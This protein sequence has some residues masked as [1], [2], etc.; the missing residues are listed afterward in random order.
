MLSGCVIGAAGA[1]DRLIDGML[2]E[3]GLELPVVATGGDARLVAPLSRRIGEVRPGLTLEG[4][5]R[6]FRDSCR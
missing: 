2:R 3:M 5:I 4:L 6:A 1:A